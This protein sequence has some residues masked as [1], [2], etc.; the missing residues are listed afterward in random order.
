M[1]A[2]RLLPDE[3]S[4]SFIQA[5]ERAWTSNFGMMNVLQVDEHRGWCSDQVLDWASEHHVELQISPGK[6]HERLAI[7]ECRHQVVRRA[8]ELFLFESKEYSNEGIIT[9]LNYIIPQINRQPNVHGYSPLQWTLGYTPTLPGNLTDEKLPPCN[10]L[11]TDAFRQK[12][13]YQ[14][15]ATMAITKASS[16]DRFRRALLRQYRGVLS[17]LKLGNKCY[18]YRDLPPNQHSVGPKIVWRGPATIV[19]IEPELK[20]YWI[21]HGAS[22]IRASFEHVKP[23]PTIE[24]EDD[25]PR[26]EKA[27]RGLDE[28]RSRGTT[29]FLD[30]TKSNKRSLTDLES[31]EE[32][33]SPDHD[34]DDGHDVG[35]PDRPFGLKRTLSDPTNDHVDKAARESADEIPPAA[36]DDDMYFPGTPLPDDF[37]IPEDQDPFFQDLTIDNEAIL[38]PPEPE[39]PSSQQPGDSSERQTVGSGGSHPTAQEI[40]N[41][42]TTT[43]Q[44]PASASPAEPTIDGETFEQ[45]RQR[46]DRHETQLYRPIRS[47]PGST[48]RKQQE[49]PYDAKVDEALQT[50]VDVLNKSHL[51][52]GWTIDEQGYMT[53]GATEDDW[54]LHGNHLIRRHF[55]ARN[56]TFQPDPED[57]PIDLKYLQK[58]RDIYNGK[59]HS[60][61]RWKH[62]QTRTCPTWT[63]Q[64]RFKIAPTYRKEAT[65]QFYSATDGLNVAPIKKRTDNI[66]ERHLSLSDRLAFT[67]AKRK[68]LQSFF[69]NQVWEFDDLKNAP[70]GRVLSAH[71]IL[72]WSSNEDGSPRAKARLIVQGFKDPDALSGQLRTNSPTLTRLARGFVLSVAQICNFTMFSSD[73]STAFLQGGF[74]E[75]KRTLWIRLP[76]DAKTMLGL[77]PGDTRVM[78]LRKSMYGLVDAPR[79]WYVEAISRILQIPNI[80]Q[81]PLDACCF[82]IYD[83]EKPS[84]MDENAPGELI[85]VFGIHIDDMLGCGNLNSPAYQKVKAALRDRFTFRMW[86]EDNN[87]EYCG[88]KIDVSE[89]YIT[90]HQS[91]Y[92][93]K[94]KPI[95]IP[96]E[97]KKTPNA[98]LTPKEISMLRGLIGGLQWPSTQ[99][100]PYLQCAVS[101]LAGEISTATISTLEAGNKILR[102]AKANADAGLRYHGLGNDPKDV[103]FLAYSDASF[104][105]RKDLTSQGGY[106]ITMVQSKVISG[107]SGVYNLVDWRSWKLPRVAR[108]SLSAESQACGECA[109]ALLFSTTFWKL[110]W[111]PTLQLED[112]QTPKLPQAPAIVIDAKALFDLLTKDEIQAACGSD[113]RTAIETMVCQD[114]LRLCDALTKWVSSE[115]QYADSMTKNDT[116]QLLADRLRTHMIRIRSDESFQAAKKKDAKVRRK[117]TEMFALKRPTKALQALLSFSTTSS[118]YSYD[119]PEPYERKYDSHLEFY[120][121]LIFTIMISIAFGF[122]LNYV[123]K[124]F[125]VEPKKREVQDKCI[126]AD[127]PDRDAQMHQQNALWFQ[128][129]A[130]DLARELEQAQNRIRDLEEDVREQLLQREND[131]QQFQRRVDELTTR[132]DDLRARSA[133]IQTEISDER[134]NR[135]VQLGTMPVHIVPNGECYHVRRSC[136]EHR[137]NRGFTI[138]SYRPCQTCVLRGTGAQ[139]WA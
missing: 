123:R 21:S 1:I 117:G 96:E 42:T 78:R 52:P 48:V 62:G 102:M 54:I 132:S 69:D 133:R 6:A 56:E 41:P 12:L 38:P 105:S 110:L 58:G 31:D 43:T 125:H 40:P 7:L 95:T 57:C 88:C 5:I 97:R 114:K 113:R 135:T 136:L 89:D 115:L 84:Q 33:N 8:I 116:G 72:K 118:V 107:S 81:H 119:H 106:L 14:Q 73:I 18:Y 75:A 70:E 100:A 34:D 3:K 77:D 76:R 65:E 10:L 122:L 47:V 59:I 127:L 45:M 120:T 17:V 91:S 93:H 108:S 112:L 49:A 44:E 109:D 85:G 131:R 130:D 83:P 90:L 15:Q 22:L 79:S 129:R 16:D 23:L 27:R 104:A 61:D 24:P 121:L 4:S 82:M 134:A 11:P 74:H 9:A 68:E 50:D 101:Q 37:E 29:R 60:Y 111:N 71:F 80:Y 13:E 51:P 126:L 92:L 67:Q 128:N 26:L 124:L 25:I 103:T 19:M 94:M 137:T 139:G 2:A 39:E 53:L 46:Y 35:L 86:K 98:S 55:V 64:T 87:M 36:D 28:V 63:G 99:T 30:L 32:M 138:A 66:S 20:I